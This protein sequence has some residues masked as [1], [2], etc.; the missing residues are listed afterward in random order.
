MKTLKIV[1][2]GVC[3][4]C[5]TNCTLVPG[6]YVG[7]ASSS[8]A[9][10]RLSGAPIIPIDTKLIVSG[11]PAISRTNAPYNYLVGQSDVLNIV[12]WNHPELTAPTSSQSLSDFSIL[13]NPQKSALI[14]ASQEP[15]TVVDGEGN[16]FFPFVGK[17]HVVGLSTDQIQAQLT[18][19]LTRYI[20]NPQVSVRIGVFNSQTFNVMG[21]VAQ[22]GV[23]ALT[24]K[25]VTILDGLNF[26]GGI[27]GTTADA[28]HI[29]V[30]RG[31]LNNVRV[32]WLNAKS[33]SALLLSQHFRLAANDIIYVP[34]VGLASWNRVVSQV[35]PTI[36]TVW[37]LNDML[38]ND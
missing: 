2:L 11:D 38:N 4:F 3:L 23:R 17:M 34:P 12:V 14:P 26:A 25:P 27:S 16:I 15:G 35:L 19:K 8:T 28:R 37:Q 24:N 31:D 20:R 22:P 1:F 6:T 10:S 36:Q 5:V 13:N 30:F 21:E 29:Y 18:E 33:P 9:Y 32:Y 7:A